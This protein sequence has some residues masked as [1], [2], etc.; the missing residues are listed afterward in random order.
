MQNSNLTLTDLI[1][2][3][4]TPKH[5]PK[6]PKRNTENAKT[7]VWGT[8]GARLLLE[9]LALDR[10]LQLIKR[11]LRMLAVIRRVLLVALLLLTVVGSRGEAP[12][13]Y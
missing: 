13:T 3:R 12:R 6:T 11:C 1:S 5:K 10:M 8:L 9:V 7:P 2:G 4:K